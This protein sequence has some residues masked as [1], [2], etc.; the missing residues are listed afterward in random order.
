MLE[1][2]NFLIIIILITMHEKTMDITV[3]IAAPFIPRLSV[4]IKNG[5]SIALIIFSFTSRI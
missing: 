2:Y 5:S 3:A 4:N 1:L